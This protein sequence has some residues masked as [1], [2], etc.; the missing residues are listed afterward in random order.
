MTAQH[1][2]QSATAPAADSQPGAKMRQLTAQLYRL[3]KAPIPEQALRALLDDVTDTL[4]SLVEAG[5][6]A[7]AHKLGAAAKSLRLPVRN[8]DL[9]RSLVFAGQGDPLAARESL[10]EELR[11]FPDNDAA[12]H[13][14]ELLDSQHDHEEAAGL[15]P[16]LSTVLPVIRS[17]TMVG[18]PRLKSLFALAKH[19]CLAD[20]PGDFA[21]CGVAGGGSSALLAFVIRRFS[22]RARV[23]Y[24]FDTFSGMPDPG[25]QDTHQGTNAQDSGW[26]AGTCAAPVESLYAVCRR[27]GVDDLIRPVP[28]FF[29]DTLPAAAA[30]IP[31]LAM[32]HM[33][34]DWYD[35]TRDILVNLFDLVTPGSPI[36]V[37]DFGYWEG[38][39]QALADF[40]AA[41]GLS[42][43]LRRIPGGVG[44]VFFK[45]VA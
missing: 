37:D 40:T 4:R 28:G 1:D 16:E 7:P 34:G 44:A 18:L 29:K 2:D 20:I 42:L 19:A 43:S 27:I 3:A 35:S 13:M 24:C 36:Q 5:E 38:C 12:R 45:P 26:G 32:L 23:L 8:L 25:P 39:D 11:Y 9:W 15:D 14:L 22:R 10:K 21:E 6:Y 33:D 31:A 30:S 41:R 17:Y